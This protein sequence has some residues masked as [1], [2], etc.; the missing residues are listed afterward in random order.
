[1]WAVSIADKIHNA[2]DFI[3][4]YEMKGAD[5]WKAFT[6][7][8]QQKIWFEKLVYSEVSKVWQHPLLDEYATYIEKLEAL[9]D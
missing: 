7:G 5:S 1:V 9:E 4:F 2:T 8:K 6:R 3:C